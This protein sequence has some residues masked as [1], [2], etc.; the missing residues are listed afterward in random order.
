MRGG[1]LGSVQPYEGCWTSCSFPVLIDRTGQSRMMS[2]SDVI[3]L[4]TGD[5]PTDNPVEDV[6]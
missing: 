1:Y 5:L 3:V 4:A 6:G 2:T